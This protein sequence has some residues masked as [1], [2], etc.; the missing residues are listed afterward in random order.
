MAPLCQRGAVP[1]SFHCCLSC[2]SLKLPEQ[3]AAFL[4]AM[5]WAFTITLCGVQLW[6]V[7]PDINLVPKSGYFIHTR[8]L[9]LVLMEIFSS[10][11]LF[12]HEISILETPHCKLIC[13]IFSDSSVSWNGCPA[14]WL[15]FTWLSSCPVPKYSNLTCSRHGRWQ[16]K[17]NQPAH[18]QRWEHCESIRHRSFSL[19]GLHENS[20]S[21]CQMKELAFS[22]VFFFLFFPPTHHKASTHLRHGNLGKNAKV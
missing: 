6:V 2:S 20:V 16:G 22:F 11:S 18:K 10:K 8:Y 21:N 9:F 14:P 17:E 1:V 3:F 13:D 19:E 4:G 15:L 7:T 5:K 12:C